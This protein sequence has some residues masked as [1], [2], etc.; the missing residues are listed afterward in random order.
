MDTCAYE[1]I[2]WIGHRLLKAGRMPLI[3]LAVGVV[4]TGCAGMNQKFAA[5][6]AV[7]LAPFA[8]YTISMLAEADYGFTKDE[9]YYTRDYL[10][11]Q[12]ELEKE[13]LGL[14]SQV[15]YVGDMLLD[16]SVG[17]VTLSESGLSEPEM[18]ARYLKFIKSLEKVI[19]ENTDLSQEDFN[20]IVDNIAQQQK[21][22][23]AL[24]AAQPLVNAG[25]RY[26][27]LLAKKNE[28]NGL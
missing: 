25:S 24:N 1:R 16:Y 15:E 8:D 20:E 4:I 9:V 12:T 23:P 6:K 17:L 18:V 3:I 5:T 21:L 22:L 10:S 13:Y 14:S 7:N 11:G 28:Q 19:I 27:Q 26:I 2:K